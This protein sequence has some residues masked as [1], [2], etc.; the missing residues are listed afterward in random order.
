MR[1]LEDCFSQDLRIEGLQSSFSV[2]FYAQITPAGFAFIPEI[3]IRD[4][5]LKNQVRQEILK[6]LL[7]QKYKSSKA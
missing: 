2:G 5:V 3:Q 4:S 7:S 1:P 6:I